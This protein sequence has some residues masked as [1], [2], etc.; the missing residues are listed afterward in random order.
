MSEP[1]DRDK[2]VPVDNISSSTGSLFDRFLSSVGRS[3]RRTQASKSK[4]RLIE[5]RADRLRETLREKS[6]EVEKLRAVLEALEDGMVLVDSSGVVLLMNMAAYDMVGTE[7]EFTHSELGR[8]VR[9]MQANRQDGELVPD[10]APQKIQH[11]ER[12]LAIRLAAATTP[13]G[14]SLGTLVVI[15]DISSEQVSK[16][17]RTH[18]VTAI[19]HEL[20]TP[21]QSIKGAADL[22]EAE[23]IGNPQAAQMVEL[24]AHNVDVLD[25]MVI[26]MLDL[27]EM[28]GGTFALM[29]TPVDLEATLGAIIRSMIPD[30]QRAHLEVKLMLRNVSRLQLYADEPRLRWAIGHLLRNAIQYTPADGSIWIAAGLD[31]LNPDMVA[32]DIVDTGTGITTEDMPRIFERFYRGIARTAAGQRI[33]PRGLGQG[34]FIARA[35]AEAHGG[36]ITAHSEAGQG[37]SFSLTIPLE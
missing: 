24:L 36:T 9:T 5:A 31:D 4:D 21:M 8:T 34:L 22:L 17:I 23:L 33:D 37:A 16:R 18:F 27:A 6:G 30:V 32:I 2:L 10:D 25:R 12:L 20:R 3:S 35:V 28:G 7:D 13:Q 11:G 15:R 19:S 14:R 1:A 26:E 29:K